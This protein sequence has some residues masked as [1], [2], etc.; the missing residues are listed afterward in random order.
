MVIGTSHKIGLAA[1]ALAAPLSALAQASGAATATA[2]AA[3]LDPGTVVKTADMNFGQ[4]AKPA[5]A[6]TV[7]L[8][9]TASATCNVT[10]GLVRTGTCQPAEFTVMGQKQGRVRMREQ[11]GGII[12]LLGPGGATMQVTNITL[13]T[14]DLTPING[15]GGWNLGRHEITS[16]NGTARF[17][18]GGTLHVNAN[19]QGG[20]YNGTLQLEVNFN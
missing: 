2:E 10:G 1:L 9:P 4:I 16:N 19:Q 6:G 8:V 20:A 18:I 5:S 7:V 17:R 13:S 11:N 15:A 14:T 3:I 12:T